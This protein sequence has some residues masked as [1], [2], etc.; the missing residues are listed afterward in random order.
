VADDCRRQQHVAARGSACGAE[1]ADF[2][3]LVRSLDIRDDVD[4]SELAL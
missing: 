2:V 1:H 4:L 3:A